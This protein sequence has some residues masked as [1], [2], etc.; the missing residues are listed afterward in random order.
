MDNDPALVCAAIIQRDDEVLMIQETEDGARWNLPAGR[1]EPGE[2]PADCAEREAREET[3]MNVFPESLVGV[4]IGRVEASEK[5][6]I[7][8]VFHASILSGDPEVPEDDGVQAVEFVPMSKVPDRELRAGWIQNAV[9][10]FQ[11]GKTYPL[12]LVQDTR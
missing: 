5:P 11:D 4:Y 6:V 1:P 2:S 8:F 12:G 7:T 9:N 3:G 10:D